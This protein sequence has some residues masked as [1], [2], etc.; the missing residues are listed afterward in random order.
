MAYTIRGLPDAIATVPEDSEGWLRWR[1]R[2]LAFRLALR[3]QADEDPEARAALI[4]LCSRDPAFDLLIFGTLLEP[5]NTIDYIFAAGGEPIVYD[6]DLNGGCWRPADPGEDVQERAQ[7]GDILTIIKPAG[8]YPWIPFGFQVGIHRKLEEITRKIGDPM[9]RSDLIIE[10]SRDMGATWVICHRV[11]WKWRYHDN[12][13]AGLFSRKE[14]MVDSKD[15]RSMFYRIESLLGLNPKLPEWSYAPGTVWHGHPVRVPDWMIPAGYDAKQ[16]NL[17][18]RLIHPT[19]ANEILGEGTTSKSG[20]GTRTTES[21]IDEAAKIEDLIQMYTG[22]GAVTNHRVLLSS[23]DRRYGDGMYM[24]ANEARLAEQDPNR[25]GPSFL[26]L[27]WHLHPMRGW[28]WIDKE[29]ARYQGNPAEFEREYEINWDAGVG[30]WT[31]P[32][33]KTILPGDWPYDPELG[34]VWCAIDPALRDPT[35]IIF[36]QYDQHEEAYRAV[37]ALE[38]HTPSARYLAPIL[39]GFPAG[40]PI[41]ERYPNKSIQEVMDFTWELRRNGRPIKFVGDTF[42]ENS[43]GAERQSY[44]ESLFKTSIDLCAEYDDLPVRKIIVYTKYDEG[45]RWHRKRKE[46]LANLLEKLRF[47]NTPRVTYV[48]KC[49][50]ENRYKEQPENRL[51]VSEPKEPAHDWTSHATTACEYFA[52]FAQGIEASRKPLLLPTNPYARPTSIRPEPAGYKRV[53]Y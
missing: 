22:M 41:R 1:D 19:K 17:K 50:Q 44:Y 34:E 27:P 30:T 16:H 13:V 7:N 9:G 8:W 31:Y 12:Y 6:P 51:V 53:R 43:G 45:A 52:V 39:M 2:V 21:Y 32:G 15:S 48:L 29:R 4:E 26:S 46:C 47:N 5:R 33:A 20:I 38:L 37:E 14:D 18:N 25:P 42:G 3:K 28:D 11:A 24:L 40:H 35:S 10:K 36:F 49:I 23:A